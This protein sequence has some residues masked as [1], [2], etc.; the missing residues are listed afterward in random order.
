MTKCTNTKNCPCLMC[1]LARAINPK[2]VVVGI[3]K[4]AS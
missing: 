4:K 1:H 3:K 2:P